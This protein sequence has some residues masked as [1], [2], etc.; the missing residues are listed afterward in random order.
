MGIIPDFNQ[1][2]IDEIVDGTPDVYC[3]LSETT[4]QLCLHLLTR[5]P[6][7]ESMWTISPGN[8]FDDI[9]TN[10]VYMAQNQ[11]MTPVEPIIDGGTAATIIFYGLG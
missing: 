8:T 7:A 2:K 11:L 10:Y 1:E 9:L 6:E 5:Q 3:Q 4:L